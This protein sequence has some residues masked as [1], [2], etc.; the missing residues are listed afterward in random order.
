MLLVTSPAKTRLLGEENYMH[1]PDKA[2]LQ[3]KPSQYL[4]HH[5]RNVQSNALVKATGSLT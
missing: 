5:H 2:G 4:L 1:L 3:Y